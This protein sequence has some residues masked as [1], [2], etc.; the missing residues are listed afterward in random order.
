MHLFEMTI[1]FVELCFSTLWGVIGAVLGLA[2][3]AAVWH[4]A[5][6]ENQIALSAL[7]YVVVFVICLVVGHQRESKS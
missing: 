4:L 1:A 2:A 7:A 5:S 6:P 3:G